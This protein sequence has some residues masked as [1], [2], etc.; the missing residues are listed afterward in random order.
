M[1]EYIDNLTGLYNLFYLKENYIKFIEKKDDCYLISIDFKKLK[2]INDNF[3]HAAGDKSIITFADSAREIFTDSLI[4]RRSGDEFIIVTDI[5][6]DEIVKKLN[7]I[8]SKIKQAYEENLIPIDFSF[9]SGIKHCENNLEETMYKSDITMYSAKR[10]NKLYEDYYSELLT[11]VKNQEEFV[12]KIDK[13]IEKGL[14][15]YTVQKIFDTEGKKSV[16]SQIYSRDN[17][18]ISIFENEKFDILKTNYRIKR[19][20]VNNVE[21]LIKHILPKIGNSTKYMITIYHDT[22]LSRECNFI[23]YIKNLKEENYNLENIILSINIFGYNDSIYKLVDAIIELK[24][25]K[26]SVCIDSLDFSERDIILS[27]VSII[28][29]DYVNINK[30]SLV[31]AMNEKKYKKVLESIIKLLIDLDVIPIFANVDSDSEVDFIKK[32]SN[33]CLIRGYIYS[34]EEQLK[35]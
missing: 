13:L 6:H 3:G 29:V 30:K 35:K 25:M 24:N 11:N 4:I 1:R 27:L 16:I 32:I 10:N 8:I 23:N 21:K 14:L 7:L 33:K 12:G 34:K 5:T 2:Y 15:S 17:S 18:G 22:L 26:I 19:I 31:K 9:N 20:D 28:D